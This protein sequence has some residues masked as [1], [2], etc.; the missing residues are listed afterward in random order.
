MEQMESSE[1]VPFPLKILS[2]TANWPL[3]EKIAQRLGKTVEDCEIGEGK[4]RR[5]RH[6]RCFAV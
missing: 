6:A 1:D 5:N 2:G 4:D 3:A